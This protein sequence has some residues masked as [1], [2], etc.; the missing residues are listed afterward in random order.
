MKSQ[1]R[2]WLRCKLVETN[3]KIQKTQIVTQRKKIILLIIVEA[4]W[5]IV[6]RLSDVNIT[7]LHITA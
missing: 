4:K 1:R 5:T 7:L 6:K 3:K 2:H